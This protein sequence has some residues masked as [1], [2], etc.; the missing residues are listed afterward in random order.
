MDEDYNTI[1]LDLYF[2]VIEN[3][4]FSTP[5]MA[6]W[7]MGTKISTSLGAC[8]DNNRVRPYTTLY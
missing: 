1:I 6:V 3:I 5:Q 8:D 4:K 7:C 2:E